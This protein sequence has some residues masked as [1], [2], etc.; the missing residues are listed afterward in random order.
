MRKVSAINCFMK[1]K[2]LLGITFF[3]QFLS[4]VSIMIRAAFSRKFLIK[5]VEYLVVQMRCCAHE[6]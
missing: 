1:L 2:G 4:L 3:H 6:I 5:D